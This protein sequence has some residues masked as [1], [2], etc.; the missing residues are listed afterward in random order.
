MIKSKLNPKK[1]KK[2]MEVKLSNYSK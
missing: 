2:E 1:Y